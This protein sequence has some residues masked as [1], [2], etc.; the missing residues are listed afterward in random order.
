MPKFTVSLD[1]VFHYTGNVEVEVEADN[2]DA[3]IEAAYAMED[4]DWEIDHEADPKPMDVNV[5]CVEETLP[6][7]NFAKED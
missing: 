6:P 2:P 5:W 1:C 7:I 4:L 3:A